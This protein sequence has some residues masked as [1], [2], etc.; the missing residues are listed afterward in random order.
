MYKGNKISIVIPCYNEEE[1]LGTI[2]PLMPPFVDEIIVVDNG[3]TDTTA[4]TATRYVAKVIKEP[5]KGYGY[6]IKAGIAAAKGDIAVILDG[7]GSYPAEDIENLLNLLIDG[8]KDLVSGS[9]Y[10]LI[11]N[12][13]QPLINVMA[14]HFITAL[15][16]FLFPIK[17]RDLQ[18]GMMAFKKEKIDKIRIENNG[19]GL[20]QELKIRAR[21][22][23]DLVCD[24]THISYRQRKGQKK[25]R[26]ITDSSLNLCALFSLWFEYHAADR[27]YFDLR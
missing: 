10:P 11:N 12:E 2:C 15:A 20:S 6:A 1:G 7:D 18:T 4:E 8:K 5:R 9:R 24:E 13:A 22:D 14:N 26:A 16:G 23:P 17:I 27:S 21:M 19:M 3:S 25:F